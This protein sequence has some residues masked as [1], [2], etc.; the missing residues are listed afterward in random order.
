MKNFN[1]QLA[2]WERLQENERSRA[3]EEWERAVEEEE[4]G[5]EN[6]EGKEMV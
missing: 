4:Q 3:E 6:E 2:A 5:G 1:A